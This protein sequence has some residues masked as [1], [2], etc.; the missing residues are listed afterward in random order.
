MGVA[1]EPANRPGIGMNGRIADSAPIL[2]RLRMKEG[3]KGA[4]SPFVPLEASTK[5]WSSR[6][7]LEGG[8][9]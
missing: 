4:L 5:V 1:V 3:G 2:R 7:V 6:G 9:G 8:C